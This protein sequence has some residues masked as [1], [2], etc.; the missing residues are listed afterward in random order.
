MHTTIYDG[1]ISPSREELA[2]G[3]FWSRQE[4]ADNMGK[5]VFTPNFEDEYQRL[6][7][8]KP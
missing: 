4:I 8:N 1:P 3:K 2:G 6:F 7:G 5:G